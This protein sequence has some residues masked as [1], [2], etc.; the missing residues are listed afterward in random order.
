MQSRVLEDIE[1]LKVIERKTKEC[2]KGSRICVACSIHR[3]LIR[4]YNM[5]ICRRCFREYALDIGFTKVD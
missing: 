2:G 4:T 3:G 5:N 1:T